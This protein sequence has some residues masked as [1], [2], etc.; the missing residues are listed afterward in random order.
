MKWYRY[1]IFTFLVI[2]LSACSMSLA[3]DVTPPP[4]YQGAPPQEPSESVIANESPTNLMPP[5][6][7]AGQALY[8]E[9]CEPCHGPQGRGGGSLADKLTNPAPEIGSP[10]L[11]KLAVPSD[12]YRTITEGRLEKQM[13]PFSSLSDQQRWDVL[14]YVYSLSS[15]EE[16]LAKGKEIYSANCAT[17]HGPTGDG[18]GANGATD[19][20]GAGDFTSQEWITARS[21]ENIFQSISSGNGT[22]MPGFQSKISEEEIWMVSEYV[23]S[24]ALFPSSTFASVDASQPQSEET[25]V[26]EINSTPNVSD[27][28]SLAP[29]EQSGQASESVLGMVS[30]IVTNTSGGEIPVGL[31]I[32]LHGFDEMQVSL[33]QT[34]QLR[35]DGSYQFEN[36][37]FQPNRAFVSTLEFDGLTYGSDVVALEGGE[38]SIELP[39]EIY[40]STTDASDLTIER[41]HLF[42]EPVEDNVIR[43]IELL[44]LSNP[45]TKVVKPVSETE[46]SITFTLPE[47][48]TNLEFQDGELGGRFTQTGDGFGDLAAVRPGMNSHQIL[49]SFEMPIDGKLNL[50]QPVQ[51]NANAVVVLV[52]EESLKVKSDQLQDAGTRDVEGLIYRMYN[53]GALSAG[54]QL[55]ITINKQSGISKPVLSSGNNLGLAIGLGVL[56]LTF[57]GAGIWMYSRTRTQSAEPEKEELPIIKQVD[58]PESI[59]DAILALDDLYKEGQIAD[60]PYHERRGELKERLS[61]LLK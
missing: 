60:G 24:L 56:A 59:M 36:V 49:V 55:E 25:S 27:T 3:A 13:P 57:I 23:R 15:T 6:L 39:I 31:E 12:W 16:L 41:M 54:D 7:L 47:G 1:L 19:V 33:T 52:P 43:V 10:E 22:T 46:P 35:E 2:T 26:A 14:A 37:E 38:E 5:D 11:A 28:L 40:E 42:L 45:G 48:A 50:V 29:Q 61:E 51:Q 20:A 53:G 17:C 21:L 18:S 9:K 34:T 8:L 58:T 30:G 44:I 4:D 32:L